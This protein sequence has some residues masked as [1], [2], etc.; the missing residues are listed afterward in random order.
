MDKKD[1]TLRALALPFE[2]QELDMPGRAFWLRAE[3]GEAMAPWRDQLECLQSFRPAYDQLVAAGFHAVESLSG[4]HGLGLVSLTKHKAE[5]RALI[6]R[7]LDLLAADG[8]LVCCGAKDSGAASL[9]K[10]AAKRFGLVGTLSKHQCRVFWLTKADAADWAAEGT[11]RPVP[12]TDLVAR[13]GCFS[14]D[15]ADPGSML[16]AS[17]LPAAMSGRVADLGAGW[18]YLSHQVLGRFP[19]VD[20]IDLYEAEALALED[21]RTNLAGFGDRAAFHWCDVTQG[22]GEVAPYDWVIANPPFHEG[23]RTDPGIGQAFIRAAWK[24]I[25]R[26][27]KFWLVANRHLPYEAELRRW[28][29]DVETITQAE[30]FK[31]FQAS[32]R[33]DR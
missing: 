24:A 18:G 31:V 23:A 7:G 17:L 22:V 28:F 19:A 12:G 21:A 9:E 13:A 30:G 15:H 1:D 29:R 5:N 3:A 10:E 33:H 27:G 2:R 11:P 8:M 32:N 20:K 6:A 26:R 25:R 16:L 4:G 14:P